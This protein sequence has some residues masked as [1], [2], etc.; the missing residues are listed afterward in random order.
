MKYVYTLFSIAM[1][2][3]IVSVYPKKAHTN[4]TGAPTGNTG[5]PFDNGG[6]TCGQAGCHGSTPTPQAGM[7]TTDIPAS[8]YVP[9]TDYTITAT[10]AL[11]GISRFGFQVSPQFQNGVQAGTMIATSGNTQ[12]ASSKFMTHTFAGGTGVNTRTWSFTWTAPAA[13]KGPVTFWGA[14]V[15]A[16]NNGLSDPG[17]KVFTS[18]TSVSESGHLAVKDFTE[19][20]M[21]VFPVPFGNELYIEK[22]SSNIE[23]GIVKIYSLDGKLINESNMSGN[24]HTINTSSLAKGIYI[25]KLETGNTTLMQKVSKL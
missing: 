17:D 19:A 8:G 16:N 5:S 10:V 6:T 11:N 12:L 23:N 25:V 13:G 1:L 14:F 7:I 3:V 24:L 15:A 2:F 22:G 20:G 4:S 21:S 9:G 18:K